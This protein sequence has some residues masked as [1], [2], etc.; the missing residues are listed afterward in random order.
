MHAYTYLYIGSPVHL[1]MYRTDFSDLHTANVAQRPCR[2][3]ECLPTRGRVPFI[4]IMSVISQQ[5]SIDIGCSQTY[6]LS[7][8]IS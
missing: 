8:G 3:R 2:Y 6:M 5:M 1:S 7:T 4:S